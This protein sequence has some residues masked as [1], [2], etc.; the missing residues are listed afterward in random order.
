MT[1]T[2]IATMLC[3]HMALIYT[4]LHHIWK[5]NS[6][7]LAAMSDAFAVI[8]VIAF[9]QLLVAKGSYNTWRTH[10][11]K[12]GKFYYV[13]TN[14]S[15]ASVTI[16]PKI[17]SVYA[18]Q[19]SVTITFDATLVIGEYE[20]PLG[21]LFVDEHPGYATGLRLNNDCLLHIQLKCQHCSKD[22]KYVIDLELG[23]AN[24]LDVRYGFVVL[25]VADQMKKSKV[26]K[27]CVWNE[28]MSFELESEPDTLFFTVFSTNM[29]KE[30]E[31]KEEEE[32][33]VIR[34]EIVS[35]YNLNKTSLLPIQYNPYVNVKCKH[36]QFKT[37][38]IQSNA[39]PQWNQQ[40]VFG[41]A[42]DTIL[43][44][45]FNQRKPPQTPTCIGQHEYQMKSNLHA[46][47]QIF[48]L[49]INPHTES[50]IKVR[51][52]RCFAVFSLSLFCVI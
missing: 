7:V 25:N 24:N 46:K 40:I 31:R 5:R 36:K 42:A 18:Q 15:V 38:T 49:L 50:G 14:Y 30:E 11:F 2:W 8:A 34:V 1:I 41:F 28:S 16:L 4:F 52:S 26:A 9:E 27:E 17:Q 51:I 37:K 12:N 39:N 45:V 33:E 10:E 13:F 6:S 3:I 22:N 47:G 19:N 21:A 48:D 20:L 44:E 29:M 23:K 35:G 32:E 43:F